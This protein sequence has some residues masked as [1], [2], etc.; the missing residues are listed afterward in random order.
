[1]PE[2]EAGLPPVPE[3]RSVAKKSVRPSLV[4]LV[5]IIAALVG[6]WVAVTRILSEGPEITIVLSTAEGLEAGKTKVSYNGVEVGTVNTIRLSDDHKT[7]IATAQMEPKTEHF[8]VDDTKFWVVSARVSGANITGLGT[9]ISGSYIGM[10]IGQS[11]K[12]RRDF[13]ALE[14][15]PVIAR[16]VPGR[17]FQLKAPDLGSLDHGT[18]IFFRRLE[19][20][21]VSDFALDKD[22]K[23]LTVQV[24]VRAPYDQYVSGNTRFWDASGIDV[25][26]SASGLSL[27]TQSVMS[28][29][30]GGIAFETP[31]AD[32]PLPP[33]EPN[34]EF[35]LFKNRAEAF[36]LGA[37]A[38]EKFVLLFKE[39]VRGLTPGAPVELRG[40]QIGEVV[41]VD[42]QIDAQTFEFSSPVT[43]VLDSQRL[44]VRLVDLPFGADYTTV[45][46]KMIDRLIASGVRAQLQSGN[47]LTGAMFVTFDFF[48]DAP[49]ATVDW[50]QQPVRLPTAPGDL[51]AIQASVTSI[52]KKIDALPIKALGE[53]LQKAVADLDHVLLSARSTLDSGKVTLDNAGNMIGPDSSLGAEL[54]S[55]LEEVN[56]AA[57]SLRV[58]A[59]YLERH[60]ES[61]LRG[62]E[63]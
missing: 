14:V 57:S 34:T 60:P 2:R 38:P 15:P 37:V 22:G 49:P 5:P 6:A 48:P 4:W 39:T 27:Q 28:V 23:S 61:L 41:S 62:K 3:S 45:R 63:E 46:R 25:S 19:V 26:L 32:V 36:K 47:L 35:T 16:D 17:F 56:R 12:S 30:I 31:T 21:E 55:T 33:A 59:D 58:L 13:V 20:G 18:P 7:V 24:F 43:I 44:G 11:T 1:M 29:L 51:E 54:S 50:S 52:I 10:E 9:L 40:I 42:A 8:L 53:D